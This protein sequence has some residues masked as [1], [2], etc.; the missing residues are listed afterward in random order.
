M[1]II[2]N[3]K[4]IPTSNYIWYNFPLEFLLV[5][6]AQEK[7]VF[8]NRGL[9]LFFF[10]VFY[11]PSL[12]FH[13]PMIR[14][15]YGELSVIR[16]GWECPTWVEDP[17]W[18]SWGL[19]FCFVM[20][21]LLI[22]K[23]FPWCPLRFHLY[24]HHSLPAAFGLASTFSLECAFHSSKNDAN[25]YDLVFPT[26]FLCC[27][28][29]LVPSRRWGVYHMTIFL[30]NLN[31]PL[32]DCGPSQQEHLK[33]F[34]PFNTSETLFDCGLRVY[35]LEVLKLFPFL[36]RIHRTGQRETQLGTT[37]VIDQTQR[38]TYRVHPRVFLLLIALLSNS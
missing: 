37:I 29:S 19:L 16:R 34:L 18:D 9:F 25:Y 31:N 15:S 14:D 21:F 22:D 38:A 17:G 1:L 5:F 11:I 20:G 8:Y 13:Y 27:A 6:V 35:R 3:Q 33:Q 7:R 4:C 30:W 12:V 28:V 36:P 2:C 24:S 23:G 10:F 26:S 32:P